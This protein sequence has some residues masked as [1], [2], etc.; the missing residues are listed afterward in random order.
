MKETPICNHHKVAASPGDADDYSP[1][2]IPLG[3]A[4]KLELAAI[5]LEE[6]LTAILISHDFG[7][8]TGLGIGHKTK[9][10]S[11][12]ARFRALKPK[13]GER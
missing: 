2:F 8:G 12:L 9:A 10:K 11:A 6:A 4:E 5:E 1:D 7:K 13:G 3:E